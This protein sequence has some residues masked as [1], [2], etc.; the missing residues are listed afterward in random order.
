[1]TFPGRPAVHGRWPCTTGNDTTDRPNKL[2][3]RLPNA[4][5]RRCAHRSQ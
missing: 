3:K 5:E 2:E 4:E 1:M